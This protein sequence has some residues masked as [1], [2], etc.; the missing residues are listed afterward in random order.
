MT[1]EISMRQEIS[2][3]IGQVSL[4]LLYQ[5]RNLQTDFEDAAV[6]LGLGEG[7]RGNPVAATFRPNMG[8]LVFQNSVFLNFFLFLKKC[9][10]RHT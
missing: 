7:R 5:K 8:F 3:I 6:S 4:S 1:T 10:K 9:Q 2:L